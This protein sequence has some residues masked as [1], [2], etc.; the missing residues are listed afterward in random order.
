M[1]PWDSRVGRTGV[2]CELRL[3]THTVCAGDR[4]SGSSLGNEQPA[5]ETQLTVSL[6][7]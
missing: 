5:N 3:L 7:Y 6:N 2:T 1:G 4:T